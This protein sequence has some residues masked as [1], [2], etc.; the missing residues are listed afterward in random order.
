MRSSASLNS[1]SITSCVSAFARS[2]SSS[3][4]GFSVSRDSGFGSASSTGKPSASSCPILANFGFWYPISAAVSSSLSSFFL[5]ARCPARPPG[6]RAG[7]PA[8]LFPRSGSPLIAGNSFCSSVSVFR[9][10]F[11]R[12]SFGALSRTICST[13][14]SPWACASG[15]SSA[16]TP[17][18]RTID[19]RVGSSEE[20]SRKFGDWCEPSKFPPRAPLPPPNCGATNRRCRFPFLSAWIIPA[21]SRSSSCMVFISSIVRF[22]FQSSRFTGNA[23]EPEPPGGAGCPPRGGGDVEC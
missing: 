7:D 13:M 1:S 3:L 23:D 5:K 6:D 11:G 2:S 14:P 15:F 8:F 9:I 10:S 21:A 17:A 22:T 16:N 12:A 18:C 20:V 4:Y 19:L